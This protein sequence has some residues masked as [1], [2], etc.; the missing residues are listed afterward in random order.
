MFNIFKKNKEVKLFA[1]LT[2]KIIDLSEVPDDVFANKVVGD[3]VAIEPT[4]NILVSPI[5]GVI[6]QI[7]PTKH[8]VGL[9]TSQGVQILMHI[10]INTVD[11]NGKGFE[12]L[13]E[14]KSEVELGDKLIKFDPEYIKE[15][16]TSL[17]TPILIT[18]VDGVGNIEVTDVDEVA[19]G[20]DEII[21]VNNI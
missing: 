12:K 16:A 2:G 15:N 7:F 6:K 9:E 10:G 18:N 13:I 1:P 21:T 19:A 3:G 11:L 5:T 8:A 17:I 20:E 14:E 4:D